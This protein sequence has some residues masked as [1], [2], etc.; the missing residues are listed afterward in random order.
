MFW[1]KSMLLA[2]DNLTK[3]KGSTALGYRKKYHSEFNY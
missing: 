2:E 1:N 3:I